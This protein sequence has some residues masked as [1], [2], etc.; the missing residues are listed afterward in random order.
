MENVPS[1][2]LGNLLQAVGDPLQFNPDLPPQDGQPM[3][4]VEYKPMMAAVI[5]IE[6]AS[7]DLWRNHLHRSNFT[8][9]EE[10]TS[11]EEGRRSAHSCRFK[12]AAASVREFFCTLVKIVATIR[13]LEELQCPNIAEV[14]IM[15]AWTTGALNAAD[16]DAWNLVG[17]DMLRFYQT[18][19]IGRLTSLKRHI[20]DT[21]METKHIEFLMAWYIGSPC[22]VGSVRQAIRS[23][24]VL[25]G[26]SEW[27]TDLRV[28]QACQLRV[29]Y[30]DDMGGGGCCG[31]INEE[32]NSSSGRS[33]TL[34][35]FMAWGCDYL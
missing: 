5:L 28:S 20:T 9:C 8:S 16:R 22:R 1:E 33:V 13:R 3:G 21:T 10:I 25:R 18:H 4:A 27:Q 7:S 31:G 30:H 12:T 19:G 14:V 34:D 32:V 29:L 15:W 2:G 6:L 35:K 24:P 23:P 17:G 11:T 26:V